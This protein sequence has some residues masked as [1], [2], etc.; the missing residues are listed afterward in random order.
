[1]FKI[2]V[3][4]FIIFILEASVHA[5]DKIRIGY[6]APTASHINAPVAQLKGPPY[7]LSRRLINCDFS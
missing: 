4:F 1:M 2:F 6:P 5:A 7:V 3:A